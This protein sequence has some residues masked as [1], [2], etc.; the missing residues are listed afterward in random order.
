MAIQKDI[1]IGIEIKGIGAGIMFDRYAGD[2]KTALPVEDKFNFVPG[3]KRVCVPATAIMSF[4][5]AQNTDSATKRVI[6]G[7]GY[8]EI[9]YA[10]SSYSV[11]EEDYVELT[12]GGKPVVFGS[13]DADGFDES[14]GARIHYATARVK[15]GIPNP[16]VR[17][18]I[19]NGDDPWEAR[20]HM[21]V[22]RNET[23]SVDIIKRIFVT[24]GICTGFGT[25][26]PLFGK[27]SV[28]KFDVAELE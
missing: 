14:S 26:R 18:F 20:F 6:G 3:T 27:F 12:R 5:S 24:G 9:A 17:P 21:Q 23:L 13:F 11:V 7:R 8:K 19:P 4:L 25:Y 1:R 28:V 16:K 15:G 10:L 2:N 22:I